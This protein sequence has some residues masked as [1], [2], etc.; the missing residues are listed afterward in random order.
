M[1]CQNCG[2]ALNEED[3]FCP[4]CGQKVV[5]GLAA[6]KAEEV[7]ASASYSFTLNCFGGGTFSP[8][9]AYMY[10][11]SDRV[12]VFTFP[13][14]KMERMI[15]DYMKEEGK[16][17][18]IKLMERSAYRNDYLQKFS[19]SLYGMTDHDLE[20]KGISKALIYYHEL[21][22]CKFQ[23]TKSEVYQGAEDAHMTKTTGYIL[24]KTPNG[25]H[26]FTHGYSY[27]KATQALLQNT[28]GNKLKVYN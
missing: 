3:L 23:F 12:E 10:F 1:Y 17:H 18:K 7:T 26:K 24:F 20:E 19:Q 13:M 27:N 15:Y 6:S 25:K 14:K 28:I 5:Q 2:A 4:G 16:K 9:Y 21:K 22:Q 11:Y 8:K